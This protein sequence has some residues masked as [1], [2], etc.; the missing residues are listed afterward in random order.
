MCVKEIGAEEIGAK[1][2]LFFRWS[3]LLR[4]EKK[5]KVPG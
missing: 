5:K 3:L 2:A 1:A 4:L